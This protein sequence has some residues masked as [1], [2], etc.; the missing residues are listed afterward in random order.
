VTAFFN[1]D[2]TQGCA[3]LT[4][5]LTSFSSYGT[6]VSWYFADGQTATGEVQEYTF[7]RAGNYRIYHYARNACGADTA[8]LDIE[9]FPAPEADFTHPV[10]ACVGQPLRFENLSGPFQTVQWDFG[11]GQ[12]STAIHPEHVYDSAGVY[13]VELTITNTAFSCPA[14]VRRPVTVFPQPQISLAADQLRGCPPLEVCFTS[15]SEGATFL[16]W[17]F[18]DGNG[19]TSLNPC[20]I[21]T[22]SGDYR[23]RLRGADERGCFSPVDTLPI[24]VFAQPVAA[25]ESPA[26]ISCG[27]PREVEFRNRSTGATAYRWQLGA[28]GTSELTSP[29]VTY[30]EPGRYTVQLTAVNTFGCTAEAAASFELGPQP[31]ADFAP[32]LSDNC[33]P[34]AV[35]FE[36]ASVQADAFQWTLAP[37][38]FSTDPNPVLT[39]DT[40]GSYDVTLVA[41]YGGICFDSLTLSGVVNLLPRPVAAF[42][43]EVPTAAFQGLVQ[44]HNESTGADSYRWNFGDGATSEVEHPLYD[45]GGN[46]AWL[47]ELIATAANG[48]SDTAR[49]D[50]DP[51]LMRT[52]YFPNVLSP[53]TGVGDVRVFRPV[54]HGLVAW[55]LEIFSPWGQRVFV[56]NELNG[57]QP[58]GA[59]DGSYRGKILPQGA[60][61][62]KASVEYVDGVRKVYM[63]SVT[64][65]R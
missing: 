40:A 60:S 56:T 26:D 19:S 28:I 44:F 16:E 57:D 63:G 59:W 37:G 62:Y 6:N 50:V 14:T 30:T 38:Q 43:W 2:V 46:G 1:A 20:H 3:P 21:F 64:L 45:Y 41:S 42:Y 4:V 18:G 5:N 8:M 10:T 29:V 35:V 17:D 51:E 61:A 52:L 27:L 12:S 9:V 22:E 36:N 25:F 49:V 39:Y 58:A 7:E 54:G 33:A 65:L 11:D 31:L 53:E 13:Q 24:T 32:L 55:E 34:Q 23:V 47:S 15:Q 48:C